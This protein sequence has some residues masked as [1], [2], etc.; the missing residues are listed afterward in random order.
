MPDTVRGE[1]D[2]TIFGLATTESSQPASCG[3]FN[4]M[5]VK[6]GEDKVR[7]KFEEYIRSMG[8]EHYLARGEE[9]YYAGHVE[10]CW[11]GWK[12]CWRLL[13]PEMPAGPKPE[14]WPDEDHHPQSG[15]VKAQRNFDRTDLFLTRMLKCV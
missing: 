1:P 14:D 6:M 10:N 15:L 5:E 11:M 7:E 3:L 2:S 13:N 8:P 4:V 9:G 12:A